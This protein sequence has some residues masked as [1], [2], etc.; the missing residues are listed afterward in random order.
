VKAEIVLDERHHIM[1]KMFFSLF[2]TL[3]SVKTYLL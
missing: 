3:P 2:S 1:T